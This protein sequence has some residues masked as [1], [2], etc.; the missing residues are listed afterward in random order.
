MRR[1]QVTGER[2]IK[3]ALIASAVA[4]ILALAS[5]RS[6]LDVK[7][8]LES[9]KSTAEGAAKD[10]RLPQPISAADANAVIERIV[11]KGRK[12]SKKLYKDLEK[13]TAKQNLK[14]HGK[15]HK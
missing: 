8:S 2:L 13:E 7:S 9:L 11:K 1:Q 10:I 4:V 14:A 6:G 3:G 15:F 12:V 5:H